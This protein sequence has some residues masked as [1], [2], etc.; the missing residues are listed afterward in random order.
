M[1]DTANTLAAI[2][3]REVRMFMCLPFLGK[4]SVDVTHGLQ[5]WT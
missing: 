1:I 3:I 5:L 4:E 2:A